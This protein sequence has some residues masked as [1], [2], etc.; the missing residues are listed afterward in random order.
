MA[1]NAIGHGSEAVEYWQWR[2]D[3]N[4]QEEMHGTLIGADGTPVPLYSEVQQIGEDF[5]K[6]A[7]V[8]A[9][10]T[11]E[12]QVAVLQDYSSRWAVNWQRHNKAFDP[13]D[14]L[15]SYYTPLHALAG[16]VDIVAD[17]APLARYKLVVAPALNV[18]TPAAVK[19][20]MDYVHGGGHLVLGQRSALKDEDNALFTQRQP[21]PFVDLLGARVEQFYALEKPVPVSGDFGAGESPLWAEQIGV[22][23]LDTKVLMT[24]GKSNGWLD[25]QPAAV[26]RTVG[27]GSITYIGMEL[28]GAT[29]TAAGKWMLA[30]SGVKPEL[31]ALPEGVDLAIRSG[32]GKRVLI[33]T[34]YAADPQTITLPNAMEDVLTGTKSA[35]V[36]LPQYGVAVLR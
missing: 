19:N 11:V 30:M 4:G 34:N 7:P 1:W 3:L 18:L 36:T 32:G 12:S 9:G 16:S 13:I 21:G 23:S 35:T 2:S 33:L 6:A 26:T 29:A 17:T 14:S 25:G 20:L 15:M 5:D 27:S 8:L 24:Y 10:T 31:P 28:D 22:S